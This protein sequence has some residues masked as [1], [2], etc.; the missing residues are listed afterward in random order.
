MAYQRLSRHWLIRTVVFI[1]PNVPIVVWMSTHI[2][3]TL[4]ITGSSLSPDLS[5][6]YHETGQKDRIWLDK[7]EGVIHNLRRGMIVVFRSPTKRPD[8][9]AV[10]RIMGLE[11]DRIKTRS[12]HPKAE[13]QVPKGHIW[14]EGSEGVS[15]DSNT[16]GPVIFDLFYSFASSC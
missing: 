8:E 16:Y 5:P 7:R 2:G 13:E 4:P 3:S 11:G 15:L 10:K 6:L 9:W 14:V 1:I 12:P